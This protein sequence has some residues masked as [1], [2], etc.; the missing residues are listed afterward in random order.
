[1]ET[2]GDFVMFFTHQ[3]KTRQAKQDGTSNGG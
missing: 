1:V 2:V 3:P